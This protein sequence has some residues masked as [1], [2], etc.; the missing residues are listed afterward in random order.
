MTKPIRVL[1]LALAALAFAMPAQAQ[2]PTPT[3]TPKML[4]LPVAVH[5]HV[6][7]Y[8]A[9]CVW[10]SVAYSTFYTGW[11]WMTDARN[12]ARFVHPGGYF[13]F[14][15]AT[16]PVF[17]LPITMEVKVEGTFMEHKDCSGGHAREITA[18]NKGIPPKDHFGLT[19]AANAL[20]DGQTPSTYA[21]SVKPN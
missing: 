14:V 4:K 12:K 16:D 5:V 1:G 7:N 6:V 9:T 20:L 13:N 15:A 17:P 21:V 8:S 10:V 11:S 19:A 18:I 2:A 3:P